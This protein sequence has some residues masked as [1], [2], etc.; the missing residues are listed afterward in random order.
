MDK[1]GWIDKEC[2]LRIEKEREKLKNNKTEQ[3][4]EFDGDICRD[5][6]RY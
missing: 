2:K 1:D 4:R 6:D 5:T 3:L